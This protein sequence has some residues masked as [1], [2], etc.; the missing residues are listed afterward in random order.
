MGRAPGPQSLTGGSQLATLTLQRCCVAGKRRPSATVQP[1]A[2]R[3]QEVG[4]IGARRHGR[5]VLLRLR[6]VLDLPLQVFIEAEDGRH[7][8][9]AVAV[10]G[11]G[12]DSDQRP[13]CT[14]AGAASARITG[15]CQL[16]AQAACCCSMLSQNTQP[17]VISL[18]T[19]AAQTDPDL[20]VQFMGACALLQPKHP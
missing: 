20:R 2:V 11:R 19:Q 12:P 18:R 1:A 4:H 10:V 15:A 16:R 9:A 13:L 7:V 6:E 8:A 14:P 3:S 17:A 5:A